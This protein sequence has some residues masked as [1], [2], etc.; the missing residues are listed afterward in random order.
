MAENTKYI[1]L[2]DED[3]PIAGQKFVCLS[4]ISPEKILKQKENFYFDK[5]LKQFEFNKTMEKF[6]QFLNFLSFKYNLKQDLIHQDFQDYIKEEKDNLFFSTL[7]DDYKTF[8]ESKEEELEKEFNEV[9]NFQTNVRGIKVRGC[10]G[11]QEEAELRCKLIREFDPNHDVY[12]G[13]V[14]IWVPFHP[15]AYRTGK[16]EY[17]EEEL[18]HLMSE[19]VKNEKN[20]KDAFESR[21]KEAKKTAIE[22]NIKKAEK[23]GNKLTQAIDESGELISASDMTNITEEN[24]MNNTNNGEVTSADI[25]RELFEGDNIITDFKGNDHGLSEV[26]ENEKKNNIIVEE[27][28]EQLADTSGEVEAEQTTSVETASGETTETV[29]DDKVEVN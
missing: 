14:G 29:K 1:D 24:I 23:H 16:V 22:E 27:T 18:N 26:L 13:P 19:K 17:L 9:N 12:V 21:V 10:F 5:F 4:F 20:A 15:E 6:N 25:R 2:L 3:K 8:L 7:E 11:T 28:E